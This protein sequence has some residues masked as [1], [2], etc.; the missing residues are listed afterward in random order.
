MNIFI[1][2]VHHK[3]EIILN[4]Y[5]NVDFSEVI[6]TIVFIALNHDGNTENFLSRY[7][8]A[9]LQYKFFS[10]VKLATCKPTQQ[11]MFSLRFN[12]IS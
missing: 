12:E 8:K 3:F 1:F 2:I 11:N 4:I 5:S 10:S 7:E 9:L 6:L